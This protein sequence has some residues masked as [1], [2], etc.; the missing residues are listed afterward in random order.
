MPDRMAPGMILK[1][2]DLLDDGLH[3]HTWTPHPTEPGL[4]MLELL[5][6]DGC[7]LRILV[8]TN[9]VDH[10][11]DHEHIEISEII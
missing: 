9:P 4:V 8:N 10:L 2:T 7:L 1:V 6:Q 3:V 11:P 5:K